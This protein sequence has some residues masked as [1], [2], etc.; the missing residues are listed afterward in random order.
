MDS[1]HYDVVRLPIV[2]PYEMIT[3]DC[4]SDWYI[5]RFSKL[6]EAF[7]AFDLETDVD[8]L[9]YTDDRILV[10]CDDK[11]LR[12]SIPEDHYYVLHL[13]D[14]SLSNY[15]SAESFR[16]DYPI[17]LWAASDAYYYI[18]ENKMPPWKYK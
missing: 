13:K 15:Y 12:D 1:G 10:Y 9:F 11:G 5:S 2:E 7:D 18:K 3:T 14:S 4:C 16:A 6:G 8:S 17:E